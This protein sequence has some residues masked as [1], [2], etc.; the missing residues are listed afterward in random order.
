MG[1][2]TILAKIPPSRFLLEKS[3]AELVRNS[4]LLRNPKFTVLFT[5]V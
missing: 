4:H 1:G 5:R 2:E 3:V